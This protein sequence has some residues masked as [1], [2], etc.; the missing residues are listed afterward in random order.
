MKLAQ[1]AFIVS[2]LLVAVLTILCIYL[3]SPD[4]NN[5][6]ISPEQ[7]FPDARVLFLYLV[8]TEKCLPPYL[9]SNDVLGNG[10]LGFE[11]MALSYKEACDNPLLR[12]VQYFLNSDTT[13]TTGR[14]LLF[15]AAMNRNKNYLY[16][17]FMDD[18][19]VLID[20]KNSNPWRKFEA[21]LRSVEPAIAAVDLVQ[22]NNFLKMVRDVHRDRQCSRE[23]EDYISCVWFDAIFNAFHYSAV[24]RILPYDSTYDK[25]SWYA[26]QMAVIA[27]SEVLF[28]GQVVLHTQVVGENREHR[29]YPRGFYF[30]ENMF[31]RWLSDFAERHVQSS[32]L[33]QCANVYVN[34]WRTMGMEHGWSSS[35]LCLPPPPPHDV[36][37]P[38]WYSCA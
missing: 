5:P 11:V 10:S 32:K 34:Q 26:S 27:R 29:S 18:D 23:E 7:N 21:F 2:C 37:E 36:I 1:F 19:I 25:L 14:N 9:Q 38:G 4:Q 28:R 20:F 33:L 17:I 8:Q 12:H 30:P 24:H 3:Y 35:T 13:W 31:K 15:E 22:D 6:E 16:Y